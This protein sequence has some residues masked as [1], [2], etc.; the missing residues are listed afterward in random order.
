MKRGCRRRQ[1]SGRQPSRSFLSPEN[2][3]RPLKGKQGNASR[4]EVGRG[5]FNTVCLLQR[6]LFSLEED[7][8]VTAAF[9][10]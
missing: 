6:S 8:L 9:K 7:F 2:K 5:G 1:G 3:G 10:Y 4:R